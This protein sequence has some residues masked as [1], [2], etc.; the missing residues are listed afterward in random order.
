MICLKKE[1]LHTLPFGK[2]LYIWEKCIFYKLRQR[3]FILSQNH[4]FESFDK[5]STRYLRDLLEN[6]HHLIIRKVNYRMRAS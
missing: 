4:F 2:L 3:F 5:G 6:S 1:P